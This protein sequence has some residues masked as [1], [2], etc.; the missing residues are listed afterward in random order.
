MT[1]TIEIKKVKNGFLVEE[2]DNDKPASDSTSFDHPCWI[3][4]DEESLMKII[5]EVFFDD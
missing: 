3:A 1:T 2:T 5:K 4:R